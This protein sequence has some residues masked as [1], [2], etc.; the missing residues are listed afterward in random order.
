MTRKTILSLV[1]VALLCGAAYELAVHWT[2]HAHA[3]IAVK[4][5]TLE[6]VTFDSAGK[7]IEDR[8]TGRRG[9]G[10]EVMRSAGTWGVA[11][12][13]DW[14]DGAAMTLFD[15]A[16]VKMSGVLAPE[17]TAARKA[18]LLD[19]PL[20]CRWPYEDD[21]GHQY[22]AG[23]L[24]YI[25]ERT[26]G[27]YRTTDARAPDFAC[28]TLEAR[29]EDRQ[30][31]A[32]WRTRY[33]VRFVS[34]TPGEPDARLF[35]PGASYKEMSPSQVRDDAMRRAG[36]TPANCKPCFAASAADLDKEYNEAQKRRAGS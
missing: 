14:M 1:T 21:G 24:V 3:A 32:T 4:P 26:R 7:A 17:R 25:V 22:L 20:G 13:I 15:A 23:N 2:L 8:I 19:P 29:G 6:F 31:D 35:E 11:R 12:R 34:L 30:P 36:L 9:D 27:S 28:Q 18:R 33:E 16:S 10:S 5:F